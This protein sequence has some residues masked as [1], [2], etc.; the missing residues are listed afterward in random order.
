MD[1][2]TSFVGSVKATTTALRSWTRTT[3]VTTQGK[4]K[5][6]PKRSLSASFATKASPNLRICTHTRG[7]CTA[8]LLGSRRSGVREQ[9]PAMFAEIC[10]TT[11]GLWLSTWKEFIIE[12]QT[13]EALYRFS[14]HDD[15]FTGI[16]WH[17]KTFQIN[18]K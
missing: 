4:G 14:I 10:F 6:R 12:A 13:N 7:R 17:S 11:I 9:L 5:W 8:E 2:G 3:S 15:D 18:P 1:P 16:C